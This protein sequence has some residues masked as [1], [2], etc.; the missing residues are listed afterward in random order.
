MCG[1]STLRWLKLDASWGFAGAKWV[2]A[3]QAQLATNAK[4]LPARWRSPDI[5]NTKFDSQMDALRLC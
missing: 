4:L 1:H 2:Q 3:L 5:S